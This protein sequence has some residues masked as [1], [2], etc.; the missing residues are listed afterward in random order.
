LDSAPGVKITPTSILVGD[1]SAA[2]EWTMSAGEGDE[3]WSV[4]GVAI[5]NH[6]GGKITRATDYW[7]AE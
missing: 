4:R 3:A 5:L 6:A 7:D 2:V 1:T